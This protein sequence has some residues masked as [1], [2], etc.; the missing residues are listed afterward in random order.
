MIGNVPCQNIDKLL[1]K[2]KRHSSH[3]MTRLLQRTKHELNVK[4]KHEQNNIENDN[5]N[6]FYEPKEILYL[7]NKKEKSIQLAEINDT[8]IGTRNQVI[9]IF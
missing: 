3:G 1:L 5:L 7:H 8:C 4:S 6:I 2:Q 9:Y